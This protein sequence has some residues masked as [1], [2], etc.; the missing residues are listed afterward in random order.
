MKFHNTYKDVLLAVSA[1]LLTGMFSSS[2]SAQGTAAQ[3]NGRVVDAAGASVPAADIVVRNTKTQTNYHTASNSDGLYTVPQVSPGDYEV[4]VKK[5]GFQQQ[6]RAGITLVV[7]QIAQINFTLAVGSVSDTVTVTGDP[8]VLA[9]DNATAG[10]VI[11]DEQIQN[12]PLNGRSPFRLVL[13]TPGI[14]SV[15][16]TSG[17]FGDIPVNTTDDTLISIDGG[18]ASAN[19]VLIDGIPST[20]GFI[21]QLTTI[22]SVDAT[23]EF[24]VQSGPL[25]AEWGRNGG[26]V[27]NVF[28]RSGTNSL[29]GDIYEFLRNNELDA[30]DYFDKQAGKPTPIFKLNQFGGTVGGPVFI[31]KLYNGQNKFFFFVDYQGT[32]WRQGQTYISTVPTAAERGGNFKGLYTAAG[33]P[34]TIYNP[35]STVPNPALAGHY[36]RTAFASNTIPSGMINPVAAAAL[37]YVPLP[38]NVTSSPANTNNYISNAERIINEAEFG[39][40]FDQNVGAK[41][42]LFERYSFN[43]NT[44][45]QPDTFGNVG[46]PGTGALGHLNLHNYSAGANSTT[47]LNS[48]TVLSASYGFARFYW[49]RPTRSYGFNQTS[50]GLPASLVSQ[51]AFPLFPSFNIPGYSGIGG[52]NGY[53]NTGQNTHSLLISVTK[54]AGLHTLKAGVDMRLELFN[55]VTGADA[56][57]VYNFAQ[58]TTAG[59]D[60]TVFAATAGNAFASFLLG[61]TTLN[62]TSSTLGI[63]AGFSLKDLYFA[64]YAQD[65]FHVTTK[66]TLSYGLRYSANS[67]VT[68]RRNELNYFSPTQASPAVNSSF[69]NLTGALAFASP[70]NRSVYGWN[71]NQWQPRLGFAYHPYN[72]TVVRGGAGLTYMTLSLNPPGDGIGVTPNAGFSSDTAMV[73]SIDGV[74]PFTTLSNPYPNGLVQ[75]S[76]NSLGASTFLGQALTVW[77]NNLKWPNEWQWNFGVQ[78]ELKGAVFELMYEGSKGTHLV[79]P[80][81]INAQPTANYSALGAGLQTLVPNPFY[82]IIKTGAL[83]Q[84]T[85]QRQQLLLPYPQYTTITVLDDTF[86]DSTYHAMALKVTA[87]SRHGVTAL[88]SYTLSKEIAN[89]NNSL[90]TYNN[91]VNSNLNTSVQNPNKPS[92]RALRVGAGCTPADL[93]QLRRAASV[94]P[95]PCLPGQFEPLG[96]RLPRRMADQRNLPVPER[97]SAGLYRAHYRWRQPPKQDLQRH[98]AERPLDG[99]E[100]EPV[101][102]HGLLRRPAGVHLWQRVPRRRAVTRAQLHAV[103][104][105]SGEALSTLPRDGHER[106]RRSVQPVQHDSLLPAGHRGRRHHVRPATEHNWN[107]AAGA[108]G[109]EDHLLRQDGSFAGTRPEA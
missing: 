103:R 72:H 76:G 77:E 17:Q 30:D 29:H 37:A 96:E 108:A 22:P 64:G 91:A 2:A 98:P 56:N 82:G 62:S 9:T 20:T 39:I 43:R 97:L 10:Q 93:H 83:A 23:E 109:V 95:W 6:V 44:L 45:G 54:S 15:P 60:P 8:P 5:Q 51:E 79:E 3:V 65:D 75:P 46:T 1:L 25:R 35:F 48:S 57:G 26:G 66:L 18:P 94:R 67:P 31:P 34:I 42:K 13:L 24:D 68:E 58:A 74:T 14:H 89:V 36:L 88:L 63:P 104:S 71:K 86:G 70:S 106:A 84:P 52:G 69:P 102:Q 32:R 40:K 101:V 47:T 59:P 27:I 78:Q 90:T 73:S 28:T 11:G 61:T 38:N 105:G 53:L 92:R 55:S 33:A 80:L 107:S 21:N 7:D 100:S 4:S 85:V 49:G 19:E 16:S 99:T 41:E 81:N 50:L 12:L 87:P